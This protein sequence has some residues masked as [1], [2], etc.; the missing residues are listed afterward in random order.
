MAPPRARGVVW[1]ARVRYSSP[2]TTLWSSGSATCTFGCVYAGVPEE[3]ALCGGVSHGG[4]AY[5][6]SA[7]CRNRYQ[8]KLVLG[9]FLAYTVIRPGDKDVIRTRGL[10]LVALIFL[11]LC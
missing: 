8:E 3:A 1:H 4:I 11:N 7:L 10:S 9:G 6:D 5:S 2:S